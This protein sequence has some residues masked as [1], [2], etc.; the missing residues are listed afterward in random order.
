[1]DATQLPAV[2]VSVPEMQCL[3]ALPY[4]AAA[5]LTL[6][7]VLLMLLYRLCL[8]L[9]ELLLLAGEWNTTVRLL[10]RRKASSPTPDHTA[11]ET[12]NSHS[13]QHSQASP[14]TPV[15]A[16]STTESSSP[17]TG[18]GCGAGESPDSAVQPCRTC[19]S[20]AGKLRAS[21]WCSRCL[22][23]DYIKT[24]GQYPRPSS[25]HHRDPTRR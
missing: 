13:S 15:R 21:P 12:H 9:S 22:L 16:S 20:C 18:D 19:G 1:M 7:C 11:L 25:S 8:S 2:C 3:R 4:L 14:E 23:L 24:T 6:F 10:A 17:S 5:G